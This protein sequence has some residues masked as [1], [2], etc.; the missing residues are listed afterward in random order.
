MGRKSKIEASV[1]VQ[2]VEDILN[3]RKSRSGAA[4]ELNI[5]KNTIQQ[6]L[7]IYQNAGDTGL[8][9]QPKNAFYTEETK[10]NAVLDYLNGE[11][12]LM[13]IAQKYQLRSSNQL[14]NW[15]KA[16]NTHGEIKSRMSGGG[17][18]MSK[19]RNTTFEERLE[20]VKECIANDHNYGA[21]AIKYECSYQQVRNWVIKYEELGEKG[22]ED[23]RGKRAGTLPSRTKEEELRDRIAELERINKRQQMELDLLK[24]VKE[25]EKKG[26]FL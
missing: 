10:L 24:K 25:L 18:Y 17:S 6:W 15:V 2:T 3:G 20:I 26:R 22:L 5:S 16:Y 1:K 23:R 4:R 14:Q 7:V 21:A 9:E 11:G 8:L 12:S 13:M 19:A